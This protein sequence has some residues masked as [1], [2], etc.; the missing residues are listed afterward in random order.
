MLARLQTAAV[1][2]IEA[3]LVQVEVDASPGFPSFTLVG[4]PDASVRE[5]R[6]RVRTAIRHS[7]FKPP[8]HVMVNLAPADVRKAGASFDLPIALG[9]LA[10]GGEVLRRDIADTLVIGELSLDGTIQPTRGV[11]AS[12]VAAAR[13][14]LRHVLVAPGN[15]AE[16]AVVSPLHVL[17]VGSLR[18]AVEVLNDP[19]GATPWTRPPPGLPRVRSP[20]LGDVRGQA[21]ARRALEIAAAGAHHLLLIGPPGCGKTMLAKR[22]PGVLPELSQDEAIEATTIH[23]VAG[24]LEGGVGLL[25]DRPFRAPHHTASEV[26]LIGGGSVPRPGEVTLAHHGVLFLDELPEF[27][28]RALEVMRQP[29][30]EGV[31]RIA[32]AARSVSFPA[33]FQLVAAMNPCP[34]GHL[35]DGQRRC[36]C[37]ATQVHQYAGRISGPLR[38]R[39]DLVV[40][41]RAV[42][43]ATLTSEVDAEDSATVRARVLRARARQAERPNVDGWRTNAGLAGRALQA[44]CRLDAAGVEVLETAAERLG[45]TARA[46][47]RTLR[48]ARTIADLDESTYVTSRHVAEA[49]QFRY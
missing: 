22:L 4:L 49:L 37:T 1:L 40:R 47:A 10:A 36:A 45:L 41:L 29:L 43:L 24:M 35:G 23:S 20:D 39:L 21:L 18:Q 34:C 48:V 15:A 5:S 32:R 12:A 19:G 8:H 44:C 6:V 13:H 38:D 9:I 31:V 7:G 16:A 17:P 2:G 3:L 28:R 14:G 27:N 25:V 26:A 33:R 11:L 42:P 30:E 46:H